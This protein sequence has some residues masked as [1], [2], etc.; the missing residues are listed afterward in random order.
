MFAP[1]TVGDRV[2]MDGGIVDLVPYEHV[3]GRCDV[4]I[5]VN[6]ACTPAAGETRTPTVWESVMGS[7]QLMQEA[8][9]SERL[10][11]RRPDV[12]VHP[13][14]IDVPFLAFGKAALVLRQALPAVTVMKT[15]IQEILRGRAPAGGVAPR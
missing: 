8:S 4:S 14:I 10:K 13:E 1:V 15:R 11:R 2:L 12:W 7:I 3:L 5:A 9:L 6:V